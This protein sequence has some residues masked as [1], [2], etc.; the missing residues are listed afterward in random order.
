MRRLQ[1]ARER[2]G[3]TAD[4]ATAAREEAERSAA[5]RDRAEAARDAALRSL[6][7]LE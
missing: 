6:R 7:D 5:A 4:D 1:H 2:A 3:L